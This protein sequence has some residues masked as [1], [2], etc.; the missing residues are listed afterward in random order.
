[1]AEFMKGDVL[2][3][4]ASLFDRRLKMVR[5]ADVERLA[6]QQRPRPRPPRALKEGDQP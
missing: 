2:P 3:A 4:Q 1:M 5:R 6:R